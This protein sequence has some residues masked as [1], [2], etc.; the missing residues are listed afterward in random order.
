MATFEIRPMEA[1]DRERVATLAAQSFHLP[2]PS[3]KTVEYYVPE[4]W[5]VLEDRRG[6]QAALHIVDGGHWLGGAPVPAG[7]VHALMVSAECR[8]R[9]YGSALLRHGMDDLRDRSVA[10]SSL[11]ASV[12][13]AYRQD[14][15]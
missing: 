13:Q 5:V 11:F 4:A 1:D 6:V 14:G 15:Y 9:G 8:S 10:M 7:F 2:T 3:A 12:S